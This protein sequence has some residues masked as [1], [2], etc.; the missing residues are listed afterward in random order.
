MDSW[1]S[2]VVMKQPSN[3]R[4]V[5]F[6]ILMSGALCIV[7]SICYILIDRYMGPIYSAG[8]SSNQL[9]PQDNTLG[10]VILF[11]QSCF[12]S[13]TARL[14]GVYNLILAIPCILIPWAPLALLSAVPK[15][16]WYRFHACVTLFVFE[17]L[18]ALQLLL[19][20]WISWRAHSYDQKH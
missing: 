19:C 7:T 1:K 14:F 16:E 20:S 6:S 2:A 3:L 12:V 5:L 11:V 4:K 17:G 9:R 15:W 13:L 18:P 8:L 10:L